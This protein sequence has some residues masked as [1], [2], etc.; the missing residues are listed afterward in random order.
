V[1]TR[2]R[3]HASRRWAA[4]R[5]DNAPVPVLRSLRSRPIVHSPRAHDA[6][7]VSARWRGDAAGGGRSSAPAA[8]MIASPP[9]FQ[10]SRPAGENCTCTN[11]LSRIARSAWRGETPRNATL[12]LSSVRPRA[13][14]PCTSRA[15]ERGNIFPAHRRHTLPSAY[16]HVNGRPCNRHVVHVNIVGQACLAPPVRVSSLGVSHEPTYEGPGT[17]LFC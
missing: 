16:Q 15:R 11:V 1:H 4:V 6:G 7:G 13:P 5:H 14:P 10:G 12:S 2:A 8:V 3:V 17:G 9:G